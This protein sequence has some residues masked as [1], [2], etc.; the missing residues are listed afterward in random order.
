LVSASLEGGGEKRDVI[1]KWRKIRGARLFKGL[2]RA[3]KAAR[4]FEM[5][6]LLL[7]RDVPTP[8][9]LLWGELRLCGVV[10]EEYLVAERVG[11]ASPLPECLWKTARDP[12]ERHR[13]LEAAGRAVR[14]VHEAG[15][16]HGDLNSSNIL[17][18]RKGPSCQ[19]MVIDFAGAKDL[20]SLSDLHREKDL[21]RFCK[22]LLPHVREE[23]KLIFRTAYA[24]RSFS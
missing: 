2:F 23:D 12:A 14:E 10:L 13:L 11:D 6:V 3:S 21:S 16:L 19:A 15:I 9:P 5:G 7:S 4:E 18:Q 22:S 8:K 1:V 20:G 24:T 17:I